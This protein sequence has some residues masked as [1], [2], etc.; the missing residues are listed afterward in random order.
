MDR[1]ALWSLRLGFSDKQ[2]PA[3]EKWGMERFL[4]KSFDMPFFKGV[5]DLLADSPKSLADLRMQK[6]KFESQGETFK[7]EIVR[8][9][10]RTNLEMKAWWISRMMDAEF[11]LREKMTCFW[12]NH[13]V[14]TF[15]KVK[16]NHWLFVHNQ[17][18]RENAFGNFRDLTK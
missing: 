17:V 5:P 18:M 8:K 15:Q 13:F 7:K 14:S 3:I 1:A 16:V 4:Q 10:I 6:Q 2:Q 11:P 9:E 12:A